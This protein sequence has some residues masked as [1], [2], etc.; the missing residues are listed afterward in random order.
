LRALGGDEFDFGA[1]CVAIAFVADELQGEPVILRGSFV[2]KDVG[3]TVIG[4]DDGVEAAVVVDVTD[5]HAAA[6]FRRRSM[7]SR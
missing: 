4:S 2:V 7:G 6:V 5:G 1:D 3:R